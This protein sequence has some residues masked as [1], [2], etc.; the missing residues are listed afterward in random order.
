[1]TSALHKFVLIKKIKKIKKKNYRVVAEER[2]YQKWLGNKMLRSTKHVT[3]LYSMTTDVIYE[4]R[5]SDWSHQVFCRE[6]NSMV[7]A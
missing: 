4:E 6:D 5:G 1:M 2:N 3:Y 7:A